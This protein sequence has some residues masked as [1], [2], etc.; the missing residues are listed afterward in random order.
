MLPRGGDIRAFL[1]TKKK[2]SIKTNKAEGSC[3]LRGG[4]DRD[5]RSITCTEPAVRACAFPIRNGGYERCAETQRGQ[6]A[7]VY[8]RQND[9]QPRIGLYSRTCR[10]GGGSVVVGDYGHGSRLCQ[11]G[12]YVAAAVGRR[13][14]GLES[15]CGA[16]RM[17]SF[18]FGH[19]RGRGRFGDTHLP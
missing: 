10:N 12:Y 13:Y 14:N 18:A 9:L 3:P 5:G 8:T 17:D 7:E 19:R 16:D 2:K 1:T 6:S 11:L 15:R 4:R